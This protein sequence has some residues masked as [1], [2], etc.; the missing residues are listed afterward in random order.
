MSKKMI[1]PICI[2][3]SGWN[4]DHWKDIFLRYP[5][6]GVRSFFLAFSGMG[7]QPAHRG[8]MQADMVS[9]LF[10]RVSAVV[11]PCLFTIMAS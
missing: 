4:Y 11:V 5:V 3:T 2:G 6:I 8:V 9:D 1:P 7:D 10:L